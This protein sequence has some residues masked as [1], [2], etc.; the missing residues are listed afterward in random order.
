MANDNKVI[1]SDRDAALLSSNVNT[2]YLRTKLMPA[3]THKLQAA[4]DLT[5]EPDSKF[6][7]QWIDPLSPVFRQ[8]RKLDK[9]AMQ[10]FTYTGQPI[11][12]VA[13]QLYGTTSLW[14][15]LL[16]VNG[17][18]HPHEIPKGAVLYVP[19]LRDLEALLKAASTKSLRGEIVRT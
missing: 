5:Y 14:Y 16:S 6:N 15:V 11:T 18:A 9:D 1:P 10:R 19:N 13:Y 12:S 8:L 4:L 2:A 3:V 17:Y 7:K